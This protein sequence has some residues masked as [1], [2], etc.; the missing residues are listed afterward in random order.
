MRKRRFRPRR[1]PK[2]EHRE[3]PGGF[4]GTF[5]YPWMGT[6]KPVDGRGCGYVGIYK[7]GSLDPRK[8]KH[9][10]L[11][12]LW[13]TVVNADSL[14]SSVDKLFRNFELCTGGKGW[15]FDL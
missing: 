4:A 8:V 12:S 3:G 6:N 9:S 7:K 14:F 13:A 15:H 1:K 5:C 11:V 2:H 10:L